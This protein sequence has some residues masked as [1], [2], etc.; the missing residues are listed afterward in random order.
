MVIIPKH[1]YLFD[2]KFSKADSKDRSLFQ[3]STCLFYTKEESIYRSCAGVGNVK[4]HIS[5][6]F[7]TTR[8]HP[9]MQTWVENNEDVLGIDFD[10]FMLWWI[11][12]TNLI[13]PYSFHTYVLLSYSW[14]DVVIFSREVFVC[15][16]REREREGERERERE[17]RVE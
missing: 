7:P 13:L 4:A 3:E 12:M 2:S 15:R 16:V 17:S 6:F 5:P 14:G 10:K 8:H 1:Y 11:S 9:Q